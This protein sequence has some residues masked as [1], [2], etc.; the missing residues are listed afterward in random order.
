MEN[1]PCPECGLELSKAMDEEK[2]NI[3]Y[4]CENESCGYFE[5]CREDN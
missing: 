4:F 3:I 1:K 5:F 2:G